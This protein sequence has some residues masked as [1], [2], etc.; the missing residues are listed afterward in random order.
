MLHDV[1]ILS[2]ARTAIGAFGGSLGGEEPAALGA[3]V[4]AEAMRRANLE[5]PFE[6]SFALVLSHSQTPVPVNTP[7]L[8]GPESARQ[9]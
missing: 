2:G 3:L 5:P 9:L 6:T 1:V 4:A 8:K 7:H